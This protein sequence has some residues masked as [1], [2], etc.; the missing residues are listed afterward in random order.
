MK[1]TVERHAEE[2]HGFYL[3]FQ[4]IDG[5]EWVLDCDKN[6]VPQRTDYPFYERFRNHPEDFV[7]AEEFH[8]YTTA[9]IIP[10][11]GDCICGQHIILEPDCFG[12]VQCECCGRWY[13][14][15]GQR[16]NPP[17]MWLEDF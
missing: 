9:N 11:E 6:G 17:E 2:R 13:N 10:A 7:V 5:R 15:Q 14:A 16:L 8:S 4:D 3:Y 1:V 12:A